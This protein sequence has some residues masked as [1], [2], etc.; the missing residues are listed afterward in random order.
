MEGVLAQQRP[1]EAKG[2]L[3]GN[4]GPRLWR[5]IEI[6]RAR[7]RESRDGVRHVG[8]PCGLVGNFFVEMAEALPVPELHAR[9]WQRFIA[10]AQDGAALLCRIRF[11]ATGFGFFEGCF[12]RKSG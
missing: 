4:I 11:V 2:N 10:G 6:V 9:L 5:T 8:H 7:V 3:L 12:M 1:W